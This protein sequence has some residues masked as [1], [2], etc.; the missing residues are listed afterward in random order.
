[1]LNR[2]ISPEIPKPEKISIP[3]PEITT[4]ENGIPLFKVNLGT[5]DVIKVELVFDAG[6]NYS[7]APLIANATNDM[8]D[9]GSGIYSSA[10]IADMLDM[11]G[12]YFQTDCGNDFA[13]VT[14]YSLSKFIDQTL[15]IFNTIVSEP[16]FDKNEISTFAIQGK[17]RLAVS[18]NKVD[19]LARRNFLNSIYGENTIVGKMVKAEHYD[20]LNH[21]TLSNFYNDRYKKG[22]KAVVV[23]GKFTN[24]NIESIKSLI[25]SLGFSKND[26]TNINSE[27]ILNPEKI[28]ITKKDSVQSAIRIGKKMFNR[29]HPDYFSFSI[30][31]TVLGGYFGS[32][33]M[34]NIREDKGYTYGIG[35][36]LATNLKDGYFF[37]STE[38]GSDVCKDAIKEIYFETERLRNEKI[39]TDELRLV[40]NYL[41]GAFQ[42]SIDGPFAQADR[43][44][45]LYLNS[46]TNSHLEQY[47]TILAEI[48]PEKLLECAQKHLDQSLFTEVVVGP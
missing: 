22:L 15:P 46:L 6:I 4:L 34:S 1:M 24:E 47:L 35:S 17:Q 5:Q 2:T 41:F 29:K 3:E 28:Y 42:R 39:P 43:Q 45:S 13:S 37:I 38:V 48:T 25:K 16:N 14:L 30:L 33:L 10:Q 20:A 23:A 12:A 18:L 31:N 27:I 8:L 19:F 26:S 11:Y 7:T 44:K 36:G 40:K 21:D 32:R 9:E